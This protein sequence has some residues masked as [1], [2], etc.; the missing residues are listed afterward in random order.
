MRR[1]AVVGCVLLLTGLCALAKDKPRRSAVPLSVD[2]IAIYK[3]VLQQYSGESS[4]LN[5]SAETYPLDPNFEMNGLKRGECLEGIQLENLSAIAHTYHNLPV[6][7]L[8]NRMSLV[9]PHNQ[10]KIVRHND[11][12]NALSKSRSIDSAVKRAFDTA[13][14]SLS[15]IAFDKDHHHAVVAYRFWCGSLCGNGS[16]LV[17]EKV[18]NAWKKTNR[19]CAGWVS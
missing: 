17:F 12:Q 1:W 5:V 4:S 13:L 14:F 19:T 8:G 18:G 7:V 10:A 15:E 9:D 16:T 11:P 2:E 3:A 6:E